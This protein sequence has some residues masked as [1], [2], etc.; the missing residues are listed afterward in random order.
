[1]AT[2]IDNVTLKRLTTTT[3]LENKSMVSVLNSHATE[4]LTISSDGGSQAISLSSGQ[5]ITLS[6]AVGFTLPDIEIGISGSGTAEVIY[7]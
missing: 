5:S 1:M 7:Q 6:S 2:P 3:T 4:T